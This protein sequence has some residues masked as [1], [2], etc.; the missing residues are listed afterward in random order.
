MSTTGLVLFAH[1]ARDPRWAEPFERLRTKVAATRPDV[2]VALAF[3]EIMVPDLAATA[4]ALV[5]KGCTRLRIVPVFLGQGGH[6]REDLPRQV[7]LIRQ[8]HPGVEVELRMAVGEDD[9][10]L[11]SIARVAAQGLAG[12]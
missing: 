11:E 3:L 7:T 4:D 2:Q 5:A 6:V 12:P 9:G 10:V 1:G 8:R